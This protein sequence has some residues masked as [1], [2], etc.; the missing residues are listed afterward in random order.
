MSETP[1]SISPAIQ[2]LLDYDPKFAYT[3]FSP[4]RMWLAEG[5]DMDK[6]IIPAMNECMAAKKDISHVGYFTK[7]V[8]RKKQSRQ[9]TDAALAAKPLNGGRVSDEEKA[10][11]IRQSVKM[12]RFIPS[13]HETWLANYE[14]ENG[15]ITI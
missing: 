13:Y 12:G 6:D 9:D 14:A 2:L 15:E 1:P 11:Q 5:A 8:M 10:R 7:A 4:I 3:D